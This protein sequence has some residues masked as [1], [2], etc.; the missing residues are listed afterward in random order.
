MSRHVLRLLVKERVHDVLDGQFVRDV[1]HAQCSGHHLHSRTCTQGDVFI[2][3]ELL[4]EGGGHVADVELV[5]ALVGV[6]LG[7][8]SVLPL[9]IVIDQYR[10]FIIIQNI[11]SYQL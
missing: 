9:K 7:V 8:G 6:D 11:S 2:V 10:F 1:L 4:V 3:D 5:A